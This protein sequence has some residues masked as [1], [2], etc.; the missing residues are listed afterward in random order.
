MYEKGLLIVLSAPS[1]GGKDAILEKAFLRDKTLS[2]SVS[3][4]TRA[5]RDGELDGISYHFVTKPEFE[6]L[7]ADGEI[8]EYTTYCGN[9]YGTPK[10]PVLKMLDEGKNVVLK[11]EVEG[12]ANIKKMF[13]DCVLIFVL[14]P[15]MKELRRRLE[16]R[17]TET[18]ESLEKRLV[19]AREE[20]GMAHNFDYIII[21]DDLDKTVDDFCSIVAVQ[22][23]KTELNTEKIKGILAE[24]V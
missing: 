14:P 15:S 11:I 7:I 17:G 5:K 20:I 3:A 22:R 21:N 23:H 16:K 13:P 18:A 10:R 24:N 19:R 2:Y 4:T 12:A 9:Y 1:G 8:I 6:N